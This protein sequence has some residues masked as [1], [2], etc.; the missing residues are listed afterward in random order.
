LFRY[1]V[2]IFFPRDQPIGETLTYKSRI[3][4]V[5]HVHIE[6]S[7]ILN[8]QPS[9]SHF[10]N[11]ASAFLI[12]PAEQTA[13]DREASHFGVQHDFRR[14]RSPPRK[15]GTQTASQEPADRRDRDDTDPPAPARNSRDQGR[16]EAGRRSRGPG[17]TDQQGR[18]A[19][20]L[21][22]SRRMGKQW[23]GWRELDD[24]T[25]GPDR[26]SDDRRRRDR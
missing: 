23:P 19:G 13:H 22:R 14:R 21:R 15:Q 25:R 17:V 5:A 3:K 4:L 7:K 20:H 16:R 26:G 8:I 18:S 12:L 24:E 2:R 10:R 6:S 9:R 1:R 11:S